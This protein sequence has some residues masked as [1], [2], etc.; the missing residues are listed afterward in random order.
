MLGRYHRSMRCVLPPSLPRHAAFWLSRVEVST[1]EQAPSMAVVR[2]TYQTSRILAGSPRAMPTERSTNTM[3]G[4]G[5][6]SRPF[7]TTLDDRV[8]RRLPGDEH[9]IFGQ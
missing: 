5:R 9:A 1:P 3:R 2:G 8:T 4:R 6:G 7:E